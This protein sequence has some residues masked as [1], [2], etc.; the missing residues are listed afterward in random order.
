MYKQSYVIHKGKI[1]MNYAINLL[2]ILIFLLI[3]NYLHIKY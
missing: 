2:R 1:I 3:V